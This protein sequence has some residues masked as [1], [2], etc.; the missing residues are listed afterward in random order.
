MNNDIMELSPLD[1]NIENL[2][3][4][5]L[6]ETD[7]SKSKDLI[8]LFNLNQ[9]KKN[10]LRSTKYSD[11]L[12]LVI[13]QMIERITKTPDNFSNDDLLKFFAAVNTALGKINDSIGQI[14]ETPSIQINN[15]TQINVQSED[16]LSREE[17][18]RTIDAVKALLAQMNNIQEA[19]FTESEN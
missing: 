2:T 7:E 15:N 6:S 8:H 1:K 4:Q 5:I 14:D 17:K 16:K 19:E 12:E 10:V 9:S 18:E 13:K 3:K 11:M